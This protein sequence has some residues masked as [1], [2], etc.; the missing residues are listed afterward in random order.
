[1]S[2]TP[3]RATFTAGEHGA[4][5]GH[6]EQCAFSACRT[7]ELALKSSAPGTAVPPA[8]VRGRMLAAPFDLRW[9]PIL[10]VYTTH[11]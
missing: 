7:L 9:H 3:G 2:S 10:S 4:G 6:V 8:S 11:T 5:C 1:M